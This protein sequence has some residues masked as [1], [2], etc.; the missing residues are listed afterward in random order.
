MKQELSTSVIDIESLKDTAMAHAG[1]NS[2]FEWMVTVFAVLIATACMSFIASLSIKG[3]QRQMKKTE[4]EWDD[5]LVLAVRKPIRILIW[6]FGVSIAADAVVDNDKTDLMNYV[7]P[8]RVVAVVAMV[9]WAMLR[10]NKRGRS[11]FIRHREERG[12]SVDITTVHAVSKLLNISIIVSTVLIILQTLGVSVSG[13]LAF[14]GIGG[15]AVGFAAKDMLANFFGALIVYFDKP[16]KVGDWIRSPDQNI[17]GTVEEI[18]WRMTTIRTFDKRPLYVPNSIFT[19]ISVENPSRMK[20]R[21]IYE[22]IGIRY[23]DLSKMQGIVD[24]VKQML[25]DH[26]EIDD[27]QTLIVNFNAF[28]ASSCDFFVYT[29]T[30]TTDWVRFHEVKQEV[31]LKIA[32]II[33]SHAAEIA[34]PTQTLHVAS[35]PDAQMDPIGIGADVL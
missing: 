25:V 30:H 26:E 15:L 17:E 24:D 7:E 2:D 1:L 11:Y 23:D 12:K 4:T 5:V 8:V 13:V 33:R 18:G 16:F 22:T 35:V 9:A 6:V 34:F 20:N 29:F 3:V 31:L 14:G 32:D 10:F 21:R 19:T 28:S 27:K